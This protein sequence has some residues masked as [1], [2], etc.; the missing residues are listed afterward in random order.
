MPTPACPTPHAQPRMPNRAYP[1]SPTIPEGCQRQPPH[2]DRYAVAPEMPAKPAPG[3][4]AA[5]FSAGFR[6][7]H[8]SGMRRSRGRHPVGHR[9][10]RGRCPIT[11]RRPTAMIG[12]PS[13][14]ITASAGQNKSHEKTNHHLSHRTASSLGQVRYGSCVPPHP[15]ALSQS[16]PAPTIPEGCQSRAG[17]RSCAQTSGSPSPKATPP[18]GMPEKHPHGDRYAVGPWEEKTKTLRC[19]LPSVTPH[20]LAADG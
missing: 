11:G 12:H 15:H 20:T 5:A 14:I 19:L 13:G 7:R 1:A 4:R 16:C 10:H 9:P 17:G 2:W 18:G 6:F 3:C 8:P